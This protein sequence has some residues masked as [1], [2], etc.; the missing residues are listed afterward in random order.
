AHADRDELFQ[1]LTGL[2]KP[3]RRLFV[4]HGESESAQHFGDYV[5]RKTGWKVSVPGYQ[6]EFAL[7]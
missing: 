6:D 5:S 3:P 2:K 4:V 1:W 7:D